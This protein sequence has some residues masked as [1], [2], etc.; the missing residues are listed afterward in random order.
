MSGCNQ[1]TADDLRAELGYDEVA[2]IFT[3]KVAR[4]HSVTV[5][6]VAGSLNRASGHIEISVLGR[7]YW[8]A[9]LAW[10]YING[11]WP[12][13]RITFLDG[14]PANTAY[15]NLIL[16]CRGDLDGRPSLS[17]HTRLRELFDYDPD[18]GVLIAKVARRDI[19]VGDPVM[20]TNS[21]GYRQIS[22][23][24]KQY[25]AHRLIW[26]WVTGEWPSQNIDHRDGDRSNN[27][28]NNLRDVCQRVNTENQRTARST[29]VSTGLLGAHRRND[30]GRFT[31]RI[32]HKGKSLC[33]GQFNS[34]EEAHA[35]Y[36][37]AKRILHVGCTI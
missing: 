5:G 32:K 36:V 2:G 27:R 9:R 21:L 34:A 28:W 18:R 22:V 24:G 29:N 37:I 13:G 25:Q 26:L 1:L 15:R 19:A 6:E 16:E 17:A 30:T 12:P 14:N 3:R 33:L 11:C 20:G 23:D 31:S 4:H 35:A 10:L 7:S 8:A